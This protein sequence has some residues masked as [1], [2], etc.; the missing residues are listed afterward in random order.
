MCRGRASGSG[1]GGGVGV[2][3]GPQSVLMIDRVSLVALGRL[4]GKS[5]GMHGGERL[6][7][8]RLAPELRA[9]VSCSANDG[10]R[11]FGPGDLFWP[12][13]TMMGRGRTGPCHRRPNPG[14]QLTKG[15]T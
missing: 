8:S 10:P 7:P 5:V 15:A 3:V 14:V 1:L 4:S 6:I 13:P 11:W 2:C 12:S 9:C